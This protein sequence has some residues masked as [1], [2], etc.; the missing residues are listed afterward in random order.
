[1]ACGA[2][3]VV[4]GGAEGAVGKDVD[5]EDIHSHSSL[6]KNEPAW[7]FGIEL[8]N[9]L[10]LGID[11]RSLVLPNHGLNLKKDLIN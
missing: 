3:C 7:T 5:V 1:M 10:A 4:A 6:R 2:H 9:S 11:K 8:R